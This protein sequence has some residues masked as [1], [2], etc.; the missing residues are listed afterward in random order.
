MIYV[1]GQ[2]RG[3]KCEDP[4]CD[5]LSTEI[6]TK[7]F[8]FWINKGCPNCAKKILTRDQL[9]TYMKK[10]E[11]EKLVPKEPKVK[12]PKP[13]PKPIIEP[14][15]IEPKIEPIPEIMPKPTP[16]PAQEEE[17]TLPRVIRHRKTRPAKRIKNG[18]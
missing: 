10:F 13:K 4:K 5:W 9:F 8:V 1:Y 17:F 3:L 18:L 7:C 2:H 12:K 15:K 16:E 14:P 6:P 11:S